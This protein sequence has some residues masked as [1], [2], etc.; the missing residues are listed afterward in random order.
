MMGLGALGLPVTRRLRDAGFDGAGW[1]RTPRTDILVNM[2]AVTRETTN[3][4]N[5]ANLAKLPKGA[6]IIN[7]ERGEHVVDDDLIAA[8]YSGHIDSATLDVFRVEP[9][10]GDHPVWKHPRIT[11]LPHTARRP[12]PKAL[13][14]GILENIRCCWRQTG[15]G[16]IDESTYSLVIRKKSPSPTSANLSNSFAKPAYPLPLAG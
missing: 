6:A 9:L 8:I 15:S 4:I 5:A 3:I 11:V 2:P 13:T 12:H 10:S 1:A 14:T 16:D 7:L